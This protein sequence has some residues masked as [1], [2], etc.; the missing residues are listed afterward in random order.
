MNGVKPIETVCPVRSF[1]HMVSKSNSNPPKLSENGFRSAI[2]SE[3]KGF[4][5]RLTWEVFRLLCILSLRSEMRACGAPSA[6]KPTEDGVPEL[7]MALNDKGDYL[8]TQKR[9]GNSCYDKAVLTCCRYGINGNH[10][11]AGG[12]F[13]RHV[14]IV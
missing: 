14:K 2:P 4:R 6:S 10:K 7:F 5:R 12:G 1:E 13:A 3:A 11:P 9:V 8:A